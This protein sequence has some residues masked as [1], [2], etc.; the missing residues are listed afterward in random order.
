MLTAEQKVF[1]EREGYLIVRGLFRR[2]EGDFYIDHYMRQ[3]VR[4]LCPALW[5]Q[6]MYCSSTGN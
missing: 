5:S 2:D 3:K 1:Y 6:V 4:R